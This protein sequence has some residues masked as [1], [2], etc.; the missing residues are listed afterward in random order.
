MDKL[1]SVCEVRLE[2]GKSRAGDVEIG[3][4]AGEEDGVADSV[5]RGKVQEGE[6]TEMTGVRGDHWLL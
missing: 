2:P 4:K 5:K 6:D 1:L 3:L